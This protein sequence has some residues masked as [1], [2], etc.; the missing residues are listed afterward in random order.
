MKKRLVITLHE[1]FTYRLH[2]LAEEMRSEG[3][4]VTGV[5]DFGVITGE[6][7]EEDLP[8]LRDHEEVQS[9]EEDKEVGI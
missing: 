6:A 4:T 5:F 1:H 7:E 8:Q 9:L 3:L 2:D